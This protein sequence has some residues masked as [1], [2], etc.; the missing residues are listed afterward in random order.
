MILVKS[1][2]YVYN[3]LMNIMSS[4]K[5]RSYWSE[6]LKRVEKEKYILVANRGKIDWGIVDIDYLKKLLDGTGD[7]KSKVIME[8]KKEFEEVYK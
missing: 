5:V 8:L 7:S 1:E 6:T 2:T 4:T 3:V